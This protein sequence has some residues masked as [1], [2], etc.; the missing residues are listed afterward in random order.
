M[1]WRKWKI[2]LVIAVF[3]GLLTAGSG[4]AGSMNWKS[5]VAVLC[6]ALLTNL[7]SYLKTHS[8]DDLPDNGGASAPTGK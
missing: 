4:L 1:A 6:T 3:F 8:V 2:G 7:G 5:F